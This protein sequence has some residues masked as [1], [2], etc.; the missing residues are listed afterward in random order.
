ML[1]RER[2]SLMRKQKGINTT[3][4]GKLLKV[5]QGTISRYEN[6]TVKRIPYD[7]LEQI[8]SIFG[9]SV[10]DLV[11]DDQEYAP[12]DEADTDVLSES[13]LVTNK[14]D[15]ELLKWFHGLTAQERSFIKR[16]FDNSDKNREIMIIRS[17][18][19]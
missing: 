11:K 5:S 15:I 2:I 3:E 19:N 8:A 18:A 4:M 16:L 6:G 10:S 13:I 9:C 1:T 14:E 12:V 7:K 17:Q